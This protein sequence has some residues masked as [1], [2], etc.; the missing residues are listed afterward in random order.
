MRLTV[1][2]HAARSLVQRVPK[3]LARGVLVMAEPYAVGFGSGPPAVDAGRAVRERAEGLS[4]AKLPTDPVELLTTLQIPDLIAAS[5]LAIAFAVG[6]GPWLAP[7]GI[8]TDIRPS[9]YI[10][11]AAAR[12]LGR[13]EEQWARDAADGFSYD[14]PFDMQIIV[15]LILFI[16]GLLTDRLLLLA[17]DGSGT[18][19]L[20]LSGS[21]VIA[22]AFFEL[23]RPQLQ[24]RQD[25][26][27]KEAQYAEFESFA[28]AELDFSPSASCHESDIV[29][30]FRLFYPKYR[31]SSS[32]IKDEDIER[33]MRKWGRFERTPAGYYKGIELK[34]NVIKSVF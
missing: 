29:R 26:E 6:P 16:S 12:A 19:V 21:L 23:I 17:L 25:F 33:M 2:T 28:E 4:R 11:L 10:G 9:R 15:A 18:F 34:E 22:A 30:S 24:S 3:A 20:S 5:L 31:A 32:L 1:G 14:A 7:L 8:G 27:F 13:S